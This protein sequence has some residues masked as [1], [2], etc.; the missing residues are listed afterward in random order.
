MVESLHDDALPGEKGGVT[1][2]PVPDVVAVEGREEGGLIGPDLV[3]VKEERE[4]K[5][6]VV[7]NCPRSGM[8]AV[9]G[10]VERMENWGSLAGGKVG[11]SSR[12]RAGGGGVG[13]ELGCGL[14]PAGSSGARSGKR[15][16]C[17]VSSVPVESLGP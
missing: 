15:I 2:L 7:C 4:R 9:W 16:R 6:K 11:Y 17:V 1:M 14:L 12:V 3:T 10:S 8:R 5:G 13:G